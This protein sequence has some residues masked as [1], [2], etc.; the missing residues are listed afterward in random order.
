MLVVIERFG[1]ST[2]AFLFHECM[3]VVIAI[4][5]YMH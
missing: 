3:I 1:K 2:A 4:Q 5:Q